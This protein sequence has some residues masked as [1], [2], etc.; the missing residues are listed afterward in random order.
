MVLRKALVLT[1][2]GLL[3]G[4]GAAVGLGGLLDALLY[5]VSS[6]D[7]RTYAQ[8]AI[9]LSTAALAASWIPALR[10]SRVDPI[11]VIRSE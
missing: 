9:L 5:D 6:T 8:V 7:L 4:T 10:A 11:S 3:I 1:G 2:V